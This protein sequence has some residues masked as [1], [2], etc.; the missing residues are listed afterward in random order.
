TG[1]DTGNLYAFFP[2]ANDSEPLLLSAHMDTVV[3]GCHVQPRISGDLIKS[4]GTTILG[5]DDKSGIAQ[6]IWAIKELQDAEFPCGPLEILFTISEEIGLLGAKF[7]DYSRLQSRLGFA[8]D[9]HHIGELMIGA[10][11]QNNLKFVIHGRESHAGVAPEDGLNAIKIAAAALVNLPSGRIDDETTCNL[12]IINGGKATNIVPNQVF[13]EAEARSHNHQKLHDLCQKMKHI[14]ESTVA[15]HKLPDFTA[16]VEVEITE[17]YQAFRLPLDSAVVKLGLAANREMGINIE[18]AVGGGGSDANIF[19]Q[20]GI[21]MAVVGTGM[22]KVHTLQ[23]EIRIS[24]LESGKN[25]VKEVIKIH[26]GKA[27]S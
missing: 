27:L 21:S 19:N 4:D 9:T 2:S 17:S 1:G 8:L 12:G 6:I 22:N 25:W 5:S 7:C 3:P 13:I 10:P 16:S 18:P 15:L 26:S 14:M 24:D 23:E 11:S 20:H